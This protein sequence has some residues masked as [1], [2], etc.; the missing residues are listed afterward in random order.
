MV[1][2][3]VTTSLQGAAI[4]GNTVLRV[5]SDAMA[6]VGKAILTMVDWVARQLMPDL[7]E[8]EWLDRHG[9]IWLVNADG[10]TGRKLAAPA[11]GTVTF[12]GLQGIVVP[13]ATELTSPDGFLYATL[14]FVTIGTGPTECAIKSLNSGVATNQLPGTPFTMTAPIA[15]VDEVLVVDLRGG[16]ETETDDQLRAR[17][18]ARI[19]LPPMGGCAYDY[20]NWA[21]K[22]PSITRAWCAP[23]EMGMGTVTVRFMCDA[24]RAD[25]GGIPLQEDIGVVRNYLDTVRPVAVRDFFVVAPVPEPI[26]FTLYLIEDSLSLRA[27]VEGSVAAMILEKA[28]PAHQIN[29]E[30][31]AGTTI[32]NSWVSEA[33]SRVTDDF[34]LTMDDHVMPH[35]GAI[36][37]MGTVTYSTGKSPFIAPMVR[38]VHTVG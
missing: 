27:Q 23:R 29:G 7:A 31:I 3:D 19:R 22:I 37:V 11:S 13:E 20:E 17:V 2:D 26:D 25:N 18:L 6:G 34:V 5:M 9:Q 15:G 8:K 16:T 35:N 10:S 36:A 4:V 32:L 24:L 30:L 38:H 14:E 21:L 33:I 12:A 28:K 1:R